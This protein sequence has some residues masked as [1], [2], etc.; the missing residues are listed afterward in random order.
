VS[1]PYF[2]SGRVQVMF[3]TQ[4]QRVF[5]VPESFLNVLRTASDAA[6]HLQAARRSI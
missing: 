6:H 4:A 3:S 5:E 2:I 1:Y